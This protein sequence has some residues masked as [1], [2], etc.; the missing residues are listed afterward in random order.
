MGVFLQNGRLLLHVNHLKEN[1][2]AAASGCAATDLNNRENFHG[3][4]MGLI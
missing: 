1:G 2:D 3:L 4:P